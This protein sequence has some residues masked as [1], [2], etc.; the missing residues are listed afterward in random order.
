MLEIHPGIV[1]VIDTK[2]QN[3]IGHVDYQTLLG[4]N[5]DGT[6]FFIKD[7]KGYAVVTLDGQRKDLPQLDNLNELPSFEL[8]SGT[9]F[10]SYFARW[11]TGGR[12]LYY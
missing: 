1:N 5:E 7:D 11:E 10:W 3:L 4:Y 6:Y 2:S 8:Y 9:Y 12:I